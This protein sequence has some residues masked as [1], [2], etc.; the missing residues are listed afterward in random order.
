[1][2]QIFGSICIFEKVN[3]SPLHMTMFVAASQSKVNG[4][5]ES[6]SVL[7]KVS[8]FEIPN[9]FFSNKAS[10]AFDLF[11]LPSFFSFLLRAS[12]ACHACSNSV[13]NNI[14]TVLEAF[15]CQLRLQISPLWLEGSKSLPLFQQLQEIQ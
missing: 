13:R 12:K 6:E 15:R 11:S 5:C 14:T 4:M 1:M 2:F 9:K 7:S 8:G 3:I 10:A